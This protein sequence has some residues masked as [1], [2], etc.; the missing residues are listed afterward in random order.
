M[1]Y[2]SIDIIKQV[3]DPLV[4]KLG[5]DYRQRYNDEIR[6]LKKWV[7]FVQTDKAKEILER[8]GNQPSENNKSGSVILWLLGISGLD[9]VKNGIT[10]DFK[11]FG[12]ADPPDIDMDL[13]P[14]VRN[15]V[16][17]FL[18][19]KFGQERVCSVGT[20]G[21]YKTK[22][23]ILDVARAL[24][25]DVKEAMEVTKNLDAEIG[26][27][28]D[29]DEDTK[30]DK[31]GFEEICKAQPELANY[32]E[33]YPEVKEHAEIL[34]NQAKNFGTHAGGVIISNLNLTEKIPVYKDKEGRVVSSWSESGEKQELSSQG[35]IK[36]DILSLNNLP[37][38]DK[39][40]KLVKENRGIELH[41]KDIPVDDHESI[42]M[43]TRGELLGIF[44]FENPYTKKIA[45][46]V[47]CDCL[48]DIAAITSLIRP[49]PKDVG[50]DV[51]YAERKNGKKY[52]KNQILE[53]VLGDTYGILAYQEGLMKL[54]VEMAGMSPLEGNRL[55]KGASKKKK[56]IM[57]EMKPKFINGSIEKCV[58]KGLMTE[59]QV[60][61]IWNQIESTASYS[62]NKCL[63][64]DTKVK[65]ENGSVVKM[66]SLKIGDM[67][68]GFDKTSGEKYVKV[69][70][71]IKTG[72]KSCVKLS[73]EG[74]D[75][76]HKIV[77]TLN[78]KFM[79]HTDYGY[80][81]CSLDAIFRNGY[82]ICMENGESLEVISLL[83]MGEMETMDITVDSP[84]HLF[85]ANGYVT[86]N[87]HAICYSAI[88]TTELWLRYHYFYEYMTALLQNSDPKK[89]KFGTTIFDKYV[90]F[91]IDKGMIVHK[92]SINESR[93]EFRLEGNDLWYALGHVKNV[94]N[95][96]G[97]I[98]KNQPYASLEDFYDRCTVEIGTEGKTRR[99]NTRV[100]ESLI[101]AGA[102]DCFG[103]RE[104][105]F[106][107]FYE[108]T[109]RV[110]KWKLP[111]AHPYLKSGIEHMESIQDGMEISSSNLSKNLCK[112]RKAK[113]VVIGQEIESVRVLNFDSKPKYIDL[114]A[115]DQKTLD[116]ME[117]EMLSVRFSDNI[118]ARYRQQ[119]REVKGLCSYTTAK[120]ET[121]KTRIKVLGEIMGIK[122]INFKSGNQGLRVYIS[123]GNKEMNFLVFSS[124]VMLFKDR[125]I[126]GDIAVLPLRNFGQDSE[127]KTFRFYDDRE[128][129]FVL[130]RKE[131]A[132]D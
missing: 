60:N 63:S 100:V 49:G 65:K 13:M 114:P 94:S 12:K 2:P 6:D 88:T 69:T 128:G 54:A 116:D 17:A 129:G 71:I 10:P 38:I 36:F 7:L 11:K 123:D 30:L 70:D 113:S 76:L 120:L 31:A 61:E 112:I 124:A 118:Y 106:K 122:E 127:D 39:C 90:K 5:N 43:G 24:G 59:A 57:D 101:Y 55:R 95:S 4:S 29:G 108:L 42:K 81:V 58:K 79:C 26:G 28:E 33:K 53:N 93:V 97:A 46:K 109:D 77:C 22:N 78:H 27:E 91:A 121:E 56:D 16:K 34:R 25:L 83:G 45:D 99:P 103:D 105:V 87:S 126:E 96:A 102:F 111:K 82:R 47:G 104:V 132:K 110:E 35:Y 3:C 119:T 1:K 40:I 14:D 20:V 64:P 44:Q 89:E 15:E 41:R 21:T 92:P 75:G 23:V 52:E 62:F 37:I 50:L 86:S 80:N 85:F 125:F 117:K 51:E 18:V 130:K 8:R 107:H 115:L 84:E 98:V 32:F 73:L 68:L 66:S 9:P 48:G 72:R 19:E 67:I 74:K 131:D